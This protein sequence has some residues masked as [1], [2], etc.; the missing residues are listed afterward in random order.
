MAPFRA[1]DAY[2]VSESARVAEEGRQ[3]DRQL[4]RALGLR[5]SSLDIPLEIQDQPRTRQE[6][7]LSDYQL[8]LQ[9][10]QDS[11]PSTFLPVSPTPRPLGLRALSLSPEFP[12]R[13]LHPPPAP[14][15]IGDFNAVTLPALGRAVAPNTTSNVSALN[16]VDGP[17]VPRRRVPAPSTQPLRLT[18][19]MNETWMSSNGGSQIHGQAQTRSAASLHIRTGSSRR[20]FED[21]QAVQRFIVVL[22]ER[23]LNIL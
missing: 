2:R 3:L 16:G 12:S 14:N 10:S 4:D 17:S 21:P 1:L 6:Q 15:A 8:A 7:E 20:P 22:V 19:Q 5:S 11:N 18:T 23:N 13:L 9:L